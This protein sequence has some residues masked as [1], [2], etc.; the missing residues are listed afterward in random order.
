MIIDLILDRKEAETGDVI[1]VCPVKLDRLHVPVSQVYSLDKIP[2][3][4]QN[5]YVYRYNAAGFYWRVHDYYSVHIHAIGPDQIMEDILKALDSGEEP[6]V[7]EA[8]C[9]YIDANDY[10]PEIK[11]YIQSVDWL[12][13]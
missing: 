7:K 12:I 11:D 3:E 4:F 13:E 2:A 5:G 6:D 9:K 8:L 1:G 10:N